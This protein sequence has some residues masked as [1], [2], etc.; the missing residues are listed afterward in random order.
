MTAPIQPLALNSIGVYGLNKQVSPSALDPRWLIEANNIML[1]DEGRVTSRKGVK[2]ITNLIGSTSSNTD[3]VKSLGEHRSSTGG[4]TIFA[5]AKDKVYKLNTDNSPYTLD[6]QTFTGTPQTITD[7]NWEFCNFNGKLYATQAGHKPIYYDGTNWMDL[8]DAPGFRGPSSVS[9]FNPSC[10]SGDFGRLWVGGIAE[11]KDVVYYSDTLIPTTW[12]S[13]DVLTSVNP[14]TNYQ[15]KAINDEDTDSLTSGVGYKIVSFKELT[16]ITGTLDYEVVSDSRKVESTTIIK[17]IYYEIVVDITTNQNW[18]SVGGPSSAKTGGVFKCSGGTDISSLGSVKISWVALGCVGAAGVGTRFTASSTAADI[19]GYGTVRL[20]DWSAFGGSSNPDID[21]LFTSTSTQSI[22]DYGEVVLDWQALGGPK[23]AYIGNTFVS[24]STLSSGTNI[25][26]YGSVIAVTG[27]SG[28]LDLKTVWGNDEI[29]SIASFMGK[30]V[31]FGKRNIAIYNN[32][33]DPSD[34]AFALDEV[35]MGV[36]C[37]ARDSV[38]ALGDDI[39]F[40]SNSGVRS[41]QRTQVKD[42]MPLTDLS[43]NVKDEITNK[44]VSADMDQVKSQYCLCGGYYVLSFPDRNLAYVF[45]FKS[46]SGQAPRVTN[47]TFEAKKAPKS[48]LSTSDGVMYIGLGHFDYEGRIAKYSDYFDVEKEDVT[49][50]YA[51]S[52][53]CTTAGHIWESSNSKCWKDNNNTYQA[54]FSTVWL[55]FGDPSRA[56]LLKRFLAVISGGQDMAITMN[57]YRDYNTVADTAN[58]TVEKF[59][60]GRTWGAATSIWGTATYGGSAKPKEYKLSLS[61]SAKVLRMEMRGTV[62]GYKASLQN[63]IIWAKQGK[64]R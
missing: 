1:D 4:S 23:N 31:V 17:G 11:N 7:G 56:K 61:K 6:A 13:T 12:Y 46:G 10:C 19:S 29:T 42:K 43:L 45:D 3:I 60:T 38:Q 51:T 5:G 33:S 63:M 8:E 58:F 9:S 16:A 25:T 28:Y 52:G 49:T 36:G 34:A 24:D 15:I 44:I 39:I 32:P 40:L 64:I 53:A 54:E 14:A 20:G 57:W 55:D 35:I 37:V 26:A 21:D 30:L 50:T 41:L 48:F 62:K 47:W 22:S 27:A 2:Q 18:S 59:G